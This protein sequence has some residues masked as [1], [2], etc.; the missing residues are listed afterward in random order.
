[1]P[2]PNINSNLALFSH[3]YICYEVGQNNKL[4]KTQTYKPLLES[5][6]NNFIDTDEFINEH[7]F[8]R[9]SLIDL[10]KYFFINDVTF[11]EK[12]KATDNKGVVSDNLFNEITNKTNKLST[13]NKEIINKID[14]LN[15]NPLI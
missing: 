6:V 4:V 10:D 3:M 9:R 11:P 1:M 13:C 8:R 2:H 7:P 5:V 12:L 15:I 14:L